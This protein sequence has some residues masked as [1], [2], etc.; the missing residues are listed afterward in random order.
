MSNTKTV[1]IHCLLMLSS[2]E[3]PDPMHEIEWHARK[4]EEEKK[5][6]F[7]ATT[8]QIKRLHPGVSEIH[9]Y[10]D[11]QLG[12]SYLGGGIFHSY[13]P[14]STPKGQE[15]LTNSDLYKNYGCP[16]T[17][18]GFIGVTEF[19]ATPGEPLENLEGFLRA[20]DKPLTMENLPASAAR[21][22]IYFYK[23]PGSGPQ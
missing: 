12:N 5:P 7:V 15:I 14:L 11:S 3:P 8:R 19:K 2:K 21:I 22:Q 23:N 17:T 16:A 1:A 13:I 9:F 4:W 20:N 10:A 6:T 18:R